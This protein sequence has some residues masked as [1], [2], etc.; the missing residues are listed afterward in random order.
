MP[1]LT[2]PLSCPVERAATN[3]RQ[4]SPPRQPPPP[5]PSVLRRWLPRPSLQL[6]A[7]AG[8]TASNRV[9]PLLAAGSH[10]SRRRLPRPAVDGATVS[11]PRQRVHPLLSAGSRVSRRRLPRPA[12]QPPATAAT[13]SNR[14][15]TSAPASM[16]SRR[17]RSRFGGGGDWRGDGDW[18]EDGVADWGRSPRS[19]FSLHSGNGGNEGDVNERTS[20]PPT[21][22][23][24]PVWSRMSSTRLEDQ[25]VR[26]IDWIRRLG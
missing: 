2:P 16:S 11:N 23:P 18:G 17:C 26:K 15:P 25:Q 9:H 24:A 14:S 8:A 19:R 3:R 20:L 5:R 13:V 21:A 6:L 7:M 1:S 4:R 22:G 10:G 12:L